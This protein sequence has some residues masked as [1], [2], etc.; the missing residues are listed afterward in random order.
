MNSPRPR[1][2]A[3]RRISTRFEAGSCASFGHIRCGPSCKGRAP[4]NNQNPLRRS[5]VSNSRALARA[6][7]FAAAL[8]L[9]IGTSPAHAQTVG[10]SIT[11]LVTDQSGAAVPGASVSARNAATNV[12]YTA[13]SNGAGNYTITNIPVGSYVVKS[14]LSGF[15]TATTRALSIEAQQ[16]ARIDFKMAVGAIEDSV[17]VTAEVAVL[18]TE[19]ATVGEVI[20]GSTV[21]S[22]PLNGRNTGQLALLLPGALTPSPRGFNNIGSINM[23]RPFVNGNREQTNNF[24]V[25]GFDANETIDNRV[26]YQPSPDAIAQISVE[27]NNYSADVG[28]VGGAIVSS[29]IKSGSNRFS[30][31]AFEFYRNSKFD[32][33]TWENNRSKAP[34]QERKQHIY[35][36]TLGGPIRKDKLFFFADYQGSRQDA[37]GFTTASVAPE[38]WRRGD[39]S[40]VATPIIDPLTG[41]RFPNNTIPLNR[42]SASARALLNDLAKYPLPNRTVAGVTG[43]YVGETLLSIRAHQGD[44]RLDW[45]ASDKDKVWTRY[46]F[47]TYVD[48]RNK[49]PFALFMGS[50]NDQP[51][52]NVG[53]NWTRVMGSSTINELQVGYSTTKVVAETLDWAGVGSSKRGLLH[54]RR[55]ADPGPQFHRL[56]Q[57]PHRSRRHRRRLRYPREDLSAQREVHLAPRPSRV[58]VRRPVPALRPAAFLRRQQRAPRLPELQRRLHRLRVLRLPPRP[59][60][61]EGPGGGGDP[62]KPWTHLQDRIGL[63]IQ[64]DFK[65]RPNLTLNIGLRWAYTSPLVEKNNLQTNFDLKTGKQ[66]FASDSDRSL[67]KAYYKGFEPRLGFAWTV[68]EKT[69]VRGGYGIS[70]FMEGTGANLRLPMNP[71]FFYESAVTYDRT[72]GAGSLAQGF[73]GLVAGTIPSGNVRAFDPNLR[74]QFLAAVE[75]VLRASPHLRHVRADRLRRPQ[76]LEP[77]DARRGQP[78]ASRSGRPLVMGSQEHPPS[79]L[80]RAAPRH[81]H[82]HHR[83]ARPERVQRPPGERPSAAREGSRVHGFV[84]MGEGH[85]QQPRLLRSVRRSVVGRLAR[86]RRRLLAE[87]LRSRCRLGPD[88]LRPAPQLRA[89]RFL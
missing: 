31:S 40:S 42:I 60:V 5:H 46:S 82:R 3:A 67:Y 55:S 85:E 7:L 44:V 30:G 71:P 76:G 25:D 18:Q 78:G 56:G 88:V 86:Y 80:Q 16:T 15:K 69:V 65:M 48:E 89:L 84:H 52:H 12:V 17:E 11:G 51:F 62:T 70:Q 61:F 45:N 81:H 49:Q 4:P 23:N 74:P 57:R 39:L 37:P 2:Y 54:S 22:L 32:A 58:Q 36:A 26:S 33:N 14:E 59:R 41:Q 83:L 20:S 19:S 72:T 34:K 10:G 75:R 47:A 28:N 53:V 21:Q 35:G 68:N 27:T 87:H 38:A 9:A 43:N 50:R 6:A 79:A 66:I 13:V 73:A 29:V 77:R 64:D 63:F 8:A 24:T 1:V